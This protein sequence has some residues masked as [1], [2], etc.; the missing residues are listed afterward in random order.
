MIFTGTSTAD[1]TYLLE[2]REELT[3]LIVLEYFKTEGNVAGIN[4]LNHFRKYA[5]L[6]PP[7]ATHRRPSASATIL[8]YGSADMKMLKRHG[9]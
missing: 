8:V 3:K 2:G 4:Y 7:N 9:G 5:E 1:D 6:R